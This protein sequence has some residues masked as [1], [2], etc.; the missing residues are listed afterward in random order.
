[1][2]WIHRTDHHTSQLIERAVL[3]EIHQGAVAAWA[4]LCRNDI[5]EVVIERVL[6]GPRRG[7]VLAGATLA[8]AHEGERE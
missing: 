5:P 1:M 3:M 7:I 2:N 6:A 4:F 8:P